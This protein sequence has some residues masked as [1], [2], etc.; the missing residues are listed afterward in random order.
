MTEMGV[1]CLLVGGKKRKKWG[2]CFS[3]VEVGEVF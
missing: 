2:K 3:N 1:F